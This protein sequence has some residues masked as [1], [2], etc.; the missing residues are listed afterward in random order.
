[1][2]VL[3][4]VTAAVSALFVGHMA[5]AAPLPVILRVQSAP[6]AWGDCRL[7]DRLTI[8][9][10]RNPDLNVI[11]PETASRQH[12]PFPNDRNNI[13]SLLNWGTEVGGRYLLTVVV[14]REGL[15]RRKTFSV[16]VLFHR[17]ETIALITGEFRL[18]DLLK[19]R[20]VLAEPFEE[21][22]SAARQFQSSAE[23]NAADP[24]LHVTAAE[25]SSL[26]RSLETRLAEHLV[27]KISR[28]MRGR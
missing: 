4:M 26:F 12:P 17:W 20:L 18:V 13:D 25:K 1:M 3:V 10:S 23:D 27:D 16:P 7:T 5:S 22:L 21:K 24:A 9:L 6:L 2:R 11:V 28:Y 15:E 8:S 14:D 19:R